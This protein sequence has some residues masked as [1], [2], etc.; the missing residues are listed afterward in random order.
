MIRLQLRLIIA[1]AFVALFAISG[2]TVL[3][4]PA[5]QSGGVTISPTSLLLVESSPNDISYT[6]V[7]NA[8][9]MHSSGPFAYLS[10]EAIVE[11]AETNTDVSLSPSHLYFDRD[12]WNTPQT[13]TVTP[14]DDDIFNE[15]METHTITHTI[16]D[17]IAANYPTTL[18]IDS[19]TVF[20]LDNDADVTVSPATL[21]VDEGGG[22]KEYTVV[23]GTMPT[24]NVTIRS[25]VE[26]EALADVKLGTDNPPLSLF[27][28]L[29]FT[30]TNWN[31]PR[32]VFVAATDDAEFE[33][34]ET[35]DIVHVI[36][37]NADTNYP[38]LAAL[39]SVTVTV[40]DNDLDVTISPTT[41]AVAE[42]GETTDTY[43]VVLGTMPAGDVTMRANSSPDV[44]VATVSVPTGNQTDIAFTPANYNTAQTVTVK[45]VDD[46]RDDAETRT[47]T[48]RH[49]IT[50]SADT[51]SYPVISVPIGNTDVTV[52]VTDNDTAGVSVSKTALT[53]SEDGA[54]DSYTIRLDSEPTANVPLGV[55]ITG[56]SIVT[57]SGSSLLFTSV[58]WA[59]PQIVTVTAVD[60]DVDDDNA[61]TTLRHQ[62]RSE[63]A[64]YHNLHYSPVTVTV[65]DND[66]AGVTVS[67]TALTV[68][69]D[70]ATDSYTIRLDSEPT[71]EVP[72]LVDI[73]GPSIVTTSGGFLLF[74]SVTWATPQPVTVTA[75]D[76]DVDDDNA[77]TTL[78]HFIRSEDA[79][80]DN[81]HYS[82][83]TVTVTDNDTAGITVMPITLSGPF[84]LLEYEGHTR[85]LAYAVV[86]DSTPLGNVTITPDLGGSMDLRITSSPLTFTSGNWATAQRV[87]FISTDDT[88]DE[89]D[90][91]HTITNA[92]TATADTNYPTSLSIDSFTV[93]ILDNDVE[94]TEGSGTA[95]YPVAM[96][97]PPPAA[98]VTV[99]MNESSPDISVS[100][101]TLTFTTTN[102]TTFQ[103]VTVMAVDDRIDED[104]ETVTITHTS[105]STDPNYA[106]VGDSRLFVSDIMVTVKDDNDT[107]GVTV[108]GVD[109]TATEDGATASYTVVLDS[110]PRGNVIISVF[111]ALDAGDDFRVV[112]R[113]LTFTPTNWNTATTSTVVAYD[114]N[115]DE[116]D[117]DHRLS[118]Q[119]IETAD[120]TSYPLSRS[121]DSFIVTIT[122]NDTRGVIIMP[123]AVAVTEAAG[124]DNT[125]EYTVV[126]GSEPTGNVTITLGGNDGGDFITT[127]GG[128][129]F[130]S[131]LIRPAEWDTP[132]TVTVTATDDRIDEDA[133]MQ[134]ITHMVS[135]ADYGSVTAP[136]VVVTIADNDTR[137]VTIMPTAVAVTEAAGAN[138]TAEYTVVLGSEPTGNVTITLGGNDG[139]DFITT[140]GGSTFSSIVFN[141][142]NWNEVVTVTVTATDDR[143]DDDAEMQT[144]T[145]M[146]GGA[147]YGSNSVTA[148]GV[149]VTITDNDTRGV[150]ISP[151]PLPVTEG[152]T[153]DYTVVLVSAPTSDVTVAISEMDDDI[154]INK[155]SLTFT[156]ADWAMAQTVTV[157]ATDDDVD[158]T[159]P[160]A[161]ISHSVTGGDYGASENQSLT[162]NIMDED[163]SAVIIDPTSI[164]VLEEGTPG[165]IAVKLD[166]Q[167]ADDVTVTLATTSAD[168]TVTGGSLTFDAT[169]WAAA[170]TVSVTAP[171]DAD[172][173]D[174]TGMITVA[175]TSTNDAKYND[176]GHA[177]ISVTITD[178]DTAGLKLGWDGMTLY[179]GENGGTN[180]FD[181][182]LTT[183]PVGGNV[184][185]TIT[186]DPPGI[187]TVDTDPG[188]SGNQ[189]TLTFNDMDWDKGQV[190]L[191]GIDDDI[192]NT[193]NSRMA[194]ITI[195]PSGADYGSVANST[196]PVTLMNDEYR[197]ITLSRTSPFSVGEGVEVTYTIMLDTEPSEGNVI[198]NLA[199][200]DTSVVTVSPSTLTFSKTGAAI[201]SAPHGVRVMGVENDIDHLISQIQM[202][203][204]SHTVVAT[205]DY[206]TETVV[207]AGPITL[208]DND[209][210]GV[211]VDTDAIMLG[212]QTGDRTVVEGSNFTYT[213]VLDSEPTADVMVALGA[214][215]VTAPPF[216]N[217]SPISHTFTPSGPTAWNVPLE[218]TITAVNNDIDHPT[219][220]TA[221]ILHLIQ[222]GGS[223]Y[224]SESA[225][226][227]SFVVT[228]NDPDDMRGVTLSKTAQTI[229]EG[230]TTSYTIKLNSQPTTGTVTITP[231]S[232]TPE[233][234]FTPPMVTFQSGD[235][236]MAQEIT[237]R[238]RADD[239]DEDNEDATIEHTESGADYGSEG[240]TISDFVLTQTDDDTRS[241]TVSESTLTI[242]EAGMSVYTVVLGSAPEGGSVTI[243][244]SSTSSADVTFTPPSLTFTD[245]NFNWRM[246]QTI[247]VTAEAD[248]I[249]EDTYNFGVA[250]PDTGETWAIDHDV[251]GADYGTPNNVMASSVT[252]IV[253]DDDTR[254]VTVIPTSL[255][256]TEETSQDYSVALLSQ[257]TATVTITIAKATGGEG[258]LSADPP[259][260]MFTESNWADSQSVTVTAA[261]DPDS[262]SGLLVNGSPSGEYAIFTNAVS[263]GDYTTNGVTA[264]PVTAITTDDD[265]NNVSVSTGSVS[266]NEGGNAMYTVRL[267]TDPEQTVLL[268]VTL[269]NTTG[270]NVVNVM[271]STSRITFTDGSSGN[272]NVP[273]TITVESPMDPDGLGES[274]TITHA[275]SSGNYEVEGTIGTVTVTVDD[276]QVQGVTITGTDFVI[277][278]G[279][280]DS[281]T[282]ELDTQ[283][284][285]RS[286]NCSVTV[287]VEYLDTGDL[288]AIP[289]LMFD[290]AN[291][292][293]PQEVTLA[294]VDDDIDEADIESVT[295]RHAV[296]A[297]NCV[298]Y[299]S[300]TADSVSVDIE[301]NDE[302]AVIVS[303][304]TR[305][306]TEGL[307]STYTIVLDSQPLGDVTV[308]VDVGSTTKVTVESPSTLRLIFNAGNWRNAQTV[309]LGAPHDPDVEN[310]TA[311]I[312]HTVAG[313]DYASETA[314][315]VTVTI[316]DDDEEGVTITPAKLRFVEGRTAEYY[317]VL[318]TQPSV[319][320]E[321]KITILDDS[322]QVRV[323]PEELTFTR[324]TWQIAQR[325]T[326][327]SLT[328][329]DE[330]NDIVNI[331]HKVENYGSHAEEAAPVEATVAEFE[332]EEL[333]E[334]GRPADLTATVRT[335][336]ITLRWKSPVPN[337]DGRVPTSYEY[338]YTPTVLGDFES[339]HSSGA[340]WIR[341]GGST[342]RFLQISGLINLAEYTFQVRGVDAVLLAEA[343]SDD[344]LTTMLDVQETY[345][346][347]MKAC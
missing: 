203:T 163:T 183:Q 346:H 239:Y 26:F 72:L 42:A 317:V 223:D 36:L 276:P 130:N 137:G 178:N 27:E 135:G 262:A 338:R 254:G 249:D 347:R 104:D 16:Y 288:T 242:Q 170:Q 35:H 277:E 231:R 138:H 266:F 313:S 295:L 298:D 212:L 264:E 73:T 85:G 92:I 185:L 235:W 206:S 344:N 80:Y 297:T 53:V 225:M 258:T 64:K 268:D 205:N 54:T 335:G 57:T 107:A 49:T 214:H 218:V 322:D 226:I 63:D 305:E 237:L 173:V 139:G 269:S 186:S 314:T 24:G 324:E 118:H 20:V 4:G 319:G 71:A 191:T 281:Y 28:D 289:S 166:T 174:G 248:D 287:R 308:D 86:L 263:G 146:V 6:V 93:T 19:V 339:R 291:W 238:S 41:L 140:K 301:D 90:E 210:R 12:S 60:D 79:K 304:T 302:R 229:D 320:Q 75:V 94:V 250:D 108:T 190:T 331:T 330:L 256:I 325:V 129:T 294:P 67:K 21:T 40:T 293:R 126:L 184:T 143:I 299:G 284:V 106:S 11:Y 257:P 123:T 168:F 68:S 285:V 306:F 328:D 88:I 30:T 204:I 65:T 144:I 290:A 58:T 194:T 115:V 125:A 50:M 224:S 311:T 222:A 23:L 211:T 33:G 251:D 101:A 131:I 240:V 18:S 312:K 303:E 103:T 133:E 209:M 46:D 110:E 96:S 48:V 7:L 172:A 43:T 199:S 152:N 121:I 5:M 160:T 102:W 74:T 227:D 117:E 99:T 279:A 109:T 230:D 333:A 84:E 128:A 114:D 89:V 141:S 207:D 244:P 180:T 329:A 69:E 153:A 169:T 326:V 52:T 261:A 150:T 44:F 98:G 156:A 282:V 321:V 246:A 221:N 112:N 228:V 195:D 336:K 47:R 167:P 200:D 216:V 1:A 164:T 83:V 2:S 10:V 70:G 340:G 14:I 120:T 111:T 272:W 197:G 342:A 95:T 189:S 154:T 213:I 77:T 105:S 175:V 275:I 307:T 59:T 259:T 181:V 29:T 182:G 97:S 142:S 56:P 158:E 81:L 8:D 113:T 179:I 236:D 25:I 318:K 37:T 155:T 286:G 280:E 17:S 157:T 136:G 300:V 124:A 233:V 202:T 234:T 334:L 91:M 51:T 341:A 32:R 267:T 188:T 176:V 273:Q 260:L 337:D 343:D 171:H 122:D 219:D 45:A 232:S 201:W 55:S 34:S 220:Q 76:D 265:A 310:E 345:I 127:K 22:S 270:D 193:G 87:R 82:P 159:A 177:P 252:I 315:D 147:D 61:T 292:D 38:D 196:I 274:A 215:P 39:S 283:P 162:V 78:R 217:I 148:S 192:D 323:N 100:P 187:V 243:T 132:V 247:V 332:L 149:V 9:P 327:Q 62:I 134:T 296:S 13:I 119:I 161:T 255:N 66:T 145:H 309:T 278:E 15:G 245:I 116:S 151:S 241:I 165:T 316:N 271:L 198:I 208:T 3:A 31:T 253:T